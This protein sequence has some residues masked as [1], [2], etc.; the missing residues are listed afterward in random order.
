MNNAQKFFYWLDEKS[1]LFA[2]IERERANWF[3]RKFQVSQYIRNGDKLLDIGCGVCDVT[4]RLA[5][6]TKREVIGIDL[7]DFRRRG[8]KLSKV[9]TFIK[10]N[11][12]SLPFK[13]QRF[14]IV[15]MFWVLHHVKDPL[16]L[17]LE[18]HH[19]LKV[20]GRL[21]VI[22]D[23]VERER[24]GQREFIKVYDKLINL[25][26]GNHPHNNMSANEWIRLVSEHT[27]LSINFAETFAS[28][29]TLGLLQFGL[30]VWTKKKEL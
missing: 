6:Y 26:F 16:S 11:G 15:T 14:D 8:T 5:S 25:D 3:E 18:A 24:P 23:L 17:I 30:F 10:A 4:E 12:D 2:F 13:F 19:V 28:P 27:D 9:M 22:E 1:K 7:K 29:V 20:N 21:V